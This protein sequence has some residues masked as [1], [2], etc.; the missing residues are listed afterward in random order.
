MYS[1]PGG[2]FDWTSVQ[3]AVPNVEALLVISTK[4]A[5][6]ETEACIRQADYSCKYIQCS[7][8]KIPRCPSTSGHILQ[9]VNQHL[10]LAAL[11]HRWER[12]QM[13][14]HLNNYFIFMWFICVTITSI[15]R[16]YTNDSGCINKRV[17]E[18]MLYW[19]VMSSPHCMRTACNMKQLPFTRQERERY[20]IWSTAQCVTLLRPQPTEAAWGW[21]ACATWLGFRG[22]H[23]EWSWEVTPESLSPLIAAPW[24]NHHRSNCSPG[25]AYDQL[26]ICCRLLFIFQRESI[27]QIV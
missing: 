18:S 8:P 19:S 16:L 9:N 20:V 22:H 26:S 3:L 5:T 12:R 25:Y 21:R 7:M 1:L 10:C 24:Q 14:A 27:G 6:G 4:L 2:E 17:K 23:R 11:T 13:T 15:C